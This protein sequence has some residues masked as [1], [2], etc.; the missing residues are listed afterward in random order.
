MKEL[1]LTL[2]VNDTNTILRALSALPYSQVNELIAMIQKQARE[3][4]N[5]GNGHTAETRHEMSGN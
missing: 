3:Q 2:S 5:E 4:L 1:K